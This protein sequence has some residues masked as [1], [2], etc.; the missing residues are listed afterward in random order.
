MNGFTGFHLCS[1]HVAFCL[2]S[3]VSEVFLHDERIIRS[4]DYAC[5]RFS[6]LCLLNVVW[7]SGHALRV[8]GTHTSPSSHHALYPCKRQTSMLTPRAHHEY[9]VW[10]RPVFNMASNL[11]RWQVSGWYASGPRK[12]L[13]SLRSRCT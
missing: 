4:G 3:N 11:L 5:L 9:S 8:V 6:R 2:P 10:I 1:V 12:S 7:Q 13:D